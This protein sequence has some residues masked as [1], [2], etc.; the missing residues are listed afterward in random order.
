[1]NPWAALED[2][3]PYVL[4]GDAPLIDRFNRS[5]YGVEPWAIHLDVPPTPFTGNL[6]GA[7]VL[8]NLNP[9]YSDL[10]PDEFSDGAYRASVLA[11]LRQDTIP[12]T[13]MLLDPVWRQTKAGHRWWSRKARELVEVVGLEAV[14]A[15]LLVV[16]WCPYHSRKFRDLPALLPSQSFGFDVVRQAMERDAVIVAMRSFK[17]WS[18]AVPELTGYDNYFELRNVQN[19]TLS[20]R[21]CPDGAFERMVAALAR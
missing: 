1:V 21:N 3:A 17:K 2:R 6:E 7:V 14:T 19:P 11:N 18:L 16:E 15:H 20:R 8:L 9:G 5:S 4:P 10:H 13:F 12:H